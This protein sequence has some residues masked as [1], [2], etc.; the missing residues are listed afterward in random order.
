[1]IYYLLLT[2]SAVLLALNFIIT[3]A[4]Q[5]IEG[6]GVA[7]GF[8][9]N[10]FIGIATAILFFCMNGFKLNFSLFSFIISA[11]PSIFAILYTVV[12]LKVLK[13]GNVSLYSLFLMSGGMLVPYVFGIFYL[14]ERVN[15][16]RIIGILLI[17][18]AII[19]TNRDKIEKKLLINLVAI[20]ILNGLVSV[21]S[22]LHQVERN[23]PTVGDMDF[24]IFTGFWKTIIS[25]I[26]LLFIKNEKSKFIFSKKAVLP[27]IVLSAAV[28]GIAYILQLISI[29]NLPAT[30]SYPILTGGSIIFTCISGMLFFKEKPSKVQIISII[31]CFVGTLMFL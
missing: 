31:I 15:I 18:I 9:F 24:I 10:V 25:S 23:L 20:F 11:M 14:S 4:Y 7:A 1:M 30:V 16:F 27:I 6:T 17:L 13:S 5:R 28:G 12:G 26:A 8:K 21:F 3:K 29:A 22:T 2:V 19:I